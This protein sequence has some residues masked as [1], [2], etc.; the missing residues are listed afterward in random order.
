MA[1]CDLELSLDDEPASY[2]PGERISGTVRVRVDGECPCRQLTVALALRATK[3]GQLAGE[4]NQTPVEL[5]QGTWSPG[6]HSYAFELRAPEGPPTFLGAHLALTWELVA[7]ADIKWNVDPT[8]R[9]EIPVSPSTKPAALVQPAAT[10]EPADVEVDPHAP[11]DTPEV[12]RGIYVVL[13]IAVVAALGG[14]PLYLAYGVVEPL[15]VGGVITG[16]LVLRWLFTHGPL[17]EKPRRYARH[18]R[19]AGW[20][21]VRVVPAGRD[22]YR[23][24]EQ[25]KAAVACTVWVKPDCP[26]LS[27]TATLTVVEEVKIVRSS[28][29]RGRTYDT[30]LEPLHQREARLTAAAEPGTYVG[31]VPLPTGVPG[32]FD[33]DGATIQ[34][35]IT[36]VCRPRDDDWSTSRGVPLQV[37]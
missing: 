36:A 8:A 25:D 15:V 32:S 34:W 31:R 29:R 7:G 22:A 3:H 26:P 24:G 21:Q 13:A 18:V 14:I 27:V 9:V 20:P 5:H 30:Y 4:L 19:L 28:N 6:E 11:P 17:K 12:G 2:P 37:R 10:G 35:R 23:G 16:L 33:G 1:T